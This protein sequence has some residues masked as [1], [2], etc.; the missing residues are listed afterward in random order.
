[1]YA[2]TQA[3]LAHVFGVAVETIKRWVKS[4]APAK[5]SRGYDLAAWFSWRAHRRPTADEASAILNRRHK[6]IRVRRELLELKRMQGKLIDRREAEE[7]RLTVVRF[8]CG[9]MDRAASELVP[10]MAGRKPAEAKRVGQAYF[11]NVRRE[12]AGLNG[13]EH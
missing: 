6:W 8:F 10:R 11:A 2:P 1:M 9:V 4:D 7:D 13:R 3:S 5:T 12:V